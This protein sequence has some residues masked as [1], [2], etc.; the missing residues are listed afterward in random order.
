MEAFRAI[1]TMCSLFEGISQIL[2]SIVDGLTSPI[3]IICSFFGLHFF[4]K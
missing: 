3:A 2:A 1:C 4:L